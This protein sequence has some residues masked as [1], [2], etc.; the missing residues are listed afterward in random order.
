VTAGLY[1]LADKEITNDDY[2]VVL[3]GRRLNL[4]LAVDF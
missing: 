1:N 3:D 4:G 2:G